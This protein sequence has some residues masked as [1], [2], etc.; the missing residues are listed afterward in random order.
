MGPSPPGTAGT[1]AIRPRI[2]ELERRL[3]S[4]STGTGGTATIDGQIT[5]DGLEMAAAE[6]EDPLTAVK[7]WAHA[8]SEQRVDD[9][10]STY[11]SQFEP[12]GKMSRQ[13]WE[14]LRRTR[15]L[16]ASAIEVQVLLAEESE[17][18][19]GERQISFVQAY[20]SSSYQ[21]RVRKVLRLVWKDEAWKISEESVVRALP[22]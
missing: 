14:D 8:W 20:L 15:I 13:E 16:R 18:G 2:D 4:L 9:Y 1:L 12:E 19:P 11:S 3:D 10:L 22:D 6:V 21:D 7:E 17:L 5:K